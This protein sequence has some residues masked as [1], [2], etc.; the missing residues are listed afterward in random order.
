MPASESVA[1]PAEESLEQP[2]RARNGW[3]N[4]LFYSLGHFAVDVYSAALGVFQPLLASQRGVSLS[5][6]GMLGGM[7]VFAGSVLQPVWGILS[8]RFRSHLF[9]ALAP[10]AAAVFISSLGLASSFPTLMLLVFLGASGVASFHPQASAGATALMRGNRAKAMAV[11]IS[12]GSLGFALGPT[13][14]SLLLGKVGLDRSYLAAIPGVLVTLLLLVVLRPQ[15]LGGRP[16]SSTQW[17]PILAV[18]RPLSLL[19]LLVF[20]RSTVQ[21]SFTQFLP[22]YLT[23]ERGLSYESASLALSMFSSMGALGGFSGGFL[24]DRFGAH[25]VIQASMLGAVPPLLLFFTT[26]GALAMVGLALAGLILLS[27]TPINVVLA[28]RLAPQQAATVSA[29]MMGGSWGMAGMLLLPLAGLLAEK[30]SLHQV[31]AAFS[32][33]PLLGY[34]LALQLK[35]EQA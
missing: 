10:F 33:F 35:K 3:V 29:L 14:F 25:R 22:L 34:F 31:L 2:Q 24:A 21:I 19:Y 17:A 15:P 30:F 9:S 27:T 7:M 26:H 13:Y 4:L 16:Q 20:L 12:S 5:Q 8:D 23:R 28:Q 18:W 32:M 6:A 1:V 11:F